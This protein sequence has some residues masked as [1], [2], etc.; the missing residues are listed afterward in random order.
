MRFRRANTKGT[1]PPEV[2][3][4]GEHYAVEGLG[5]LSTRPGPDDATEANGRYVVVAGRVMFVTAEVNH[6]TALRLSGLP[7]SASTVVGYYTARRAAADGPWRFISVNHRLFLGSRVGPD[8][9]SAAVAKAAFA[10]S[11]Y[12]DVS[13]ALRR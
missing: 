11:G 10:G 13:A 4:S 5:I 8:Q 2:G 1:P 3:Y 6:A 12:G 9:G 7:A